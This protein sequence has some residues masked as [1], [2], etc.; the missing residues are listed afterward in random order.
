MKNYKTV[1]IPRGYQ[2]LKVEAPGVTVF[3]ETNSDGKT[4]VDA[5]CYLSRFAGEV[6]VVESGEANKTGVFMRCSR[7]KTG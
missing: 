7:K 1:S 5:T 2:G 6:W 3:I 4:L